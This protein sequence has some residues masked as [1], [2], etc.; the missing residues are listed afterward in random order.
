MCDEVEFS[1]ALLLSNDG[2]KQLQSGLDH[3]NFV[4]KFCRAIE[5]LHAI[6]I[7]SCGLRKAASQN[8]SCA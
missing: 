5:V 6:A 7:L 4:C 1:R 2:W 8:L 3:V